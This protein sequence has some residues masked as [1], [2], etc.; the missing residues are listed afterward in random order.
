M[1][2][3]RL[4]AAVLALILVCGTILDA[5]KKKKK[6]QDEDQVTQTLPLLKDPPQAVIAE[7]DRLI[8]RTSPLSA[9]GL[10]SPQVR[11]AL[12]ALIRDNKGAV[13][14]KLRA[15]VA[16]TGDVRRVQTIVSETF[17]E[18][19]LPLPALSVIQA[20]GLPMEGA[21]V[22][23]E[24][25]A[26]DKKAVNPHGL[27]F[28]SGQPASSAAK[29]VEQLETALRGIGLTGSRVLR[30]TC[31]VSLIETAND[32]RTALVAAFPD[33]AHNIVQ[34]ERVPVEPAAECEAVAALERP[35]GA[36]LRFENPGG[37]NYSQ[38]VLVSA[39]RLV[40]TG[41]QLAFQ[42]KETDVRLAMDRLGKTLESQGATY[43][44][45]V[46]SH[47]YVLSRPANEAFRKMRFDFLNRK[48]PPASTL[49]PFEGLPSVDASLGI[50]L[51]AALKH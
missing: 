51:I 25:I 27:A 15:F 24:S 26:V 11:E 48:Q 38:V 37:L 40:L 30:V 23:V 13:I 29:S 2:S 12:R 34:M 1:P 9:K 35:V 47:V 33:A 4:I 19:K 21:Q 22:V 18:R 14:V 17:A 10:L 28:L 43:H 16:G 36:D 45:I 7:T 44:D 32:A 5:R 6:G 39:P 42:E 50:D 41:T 8:F 31:F 46:M 20:G 3:F 49:L